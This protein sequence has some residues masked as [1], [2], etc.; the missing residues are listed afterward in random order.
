MTV[1]E[2]ALRLVYEYFVP[3]DR[4]DATAELASAQDLLDGPR[5]DSDEDDAEDALVAVSPPQPGTVMLV[6]GDLA[7][8]GEVSSSYDGGSDDDDE[9]DDDSGTGS[10][11]SDVDSDDEINDY[12][13]AELNER[14]DELGEVRYALGRVAGRLNQRL[15][16]TR[17]LVSLNSNFRAA[18]QKTVKMHHQRHKQYG[19]KLRCVRKRVKN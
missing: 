1:P 6:E 8:D 18:L 3:L 15:H 12:D 7:S 5:A 2:D 19:L 4:A 14:H 11:H 13:V 9:G 16:E 17:G 10:D